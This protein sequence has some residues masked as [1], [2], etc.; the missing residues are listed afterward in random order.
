MLWAQI[1]ILIV[2]SYYAYKNRP[3]TPPVNPVAFE[4]IDF[5]QFEEG[6]KQAVFFG[7]CWTSDWMIL[8]VGNYRT[9]PIRRK[10]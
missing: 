4:D 1:I 5:P 2:S 7:D 10:L 6:T 8:T 9:Y 3:K